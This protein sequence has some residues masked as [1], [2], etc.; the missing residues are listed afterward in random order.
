EPGGEGAGAPGEPRVGERAVGEQQ[1]MRLRELERRDAE[2]PLERAA[3]VPL[4]DAELSRQVRHGAVVERDGTDAQRGRE[5]EARDG[6]DRRPP[7]GQLGA[8]AEA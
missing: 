2:L 8:A 3:Q 4:A 5:G 1:A 6:V 7:R